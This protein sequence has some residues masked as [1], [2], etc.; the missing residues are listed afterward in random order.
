MIRASSA[1]LAI[2]CPPSQKLTDSPRLIPD[3]DITAMGSAGHKAFE[4]FANGL[5]VPLDD[6]A[7]AYGVDREELSMLYWSARRQWDCVRDLINEGERYVEMA[8]YSGSWSG[9]PDVVIL[10]PDQ[11]IGYVIDLKFGWKDSDYG[12]QLKAYASLV[13]HRWPSI[14]EVNVCLFWVRPSEVEGETFSRDAIRLWEQQ[15][16]RRLNENGYN[17]GRHCGYCPRCLECDAARM[18]LIQAGEV[19]IEAAQQTE[20]TDQD[21]FFLIYDAKKMLDDYIDRVD[22]MLRSQLAAAGGKIENDEREVFFQEQSRREINAK[23][24]LPVL[25]ELMGA[26][27]VDACCKLSKTAIEDTVKATAGRGQKGKAVAAVMDRLEETGAISVNKIQRMVDKRKV[28]E[29][30]QITAN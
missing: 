2:K 8:L 14:Q 24:A 9:H 22:E 13:M 25:R 15:A 19:L 11:T 12:D 7:Q 20:L 6:I 10:S 26:D 5:E 21:K 29:P 4:L 28:K 16:T 27:Q 23:V 30:L 1:P 18:Q 3:P 17:P